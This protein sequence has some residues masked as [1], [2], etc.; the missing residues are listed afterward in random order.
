VKQS[1]GEYIEV[2]GSTGDRV[3][4]CKKCGHTFCSIAENY[5]NYALVREVSLSHLGDEY[6]KTKRFCFREFFCPGC[7]TLLWVDMVQKGS[8]ILFDHELKQI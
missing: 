8:P 2:D 6:S 7:I 4:R 5:K 3:I 1:I